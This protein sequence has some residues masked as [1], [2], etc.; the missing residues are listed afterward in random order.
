M[1]V[2]LKGFVMHRERSSELSPDDVGRRIASKAVS[3]AER[4]AIGAA[5]DV[6]LSA[7]FLGGR[8]Q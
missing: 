8:R 3:G 4:D 6:Y 7:P 1:R 5:H 2:R